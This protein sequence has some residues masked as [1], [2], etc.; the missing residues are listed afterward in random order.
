MAGSEPAPESRTVCGDP[1][2]TLRFPESHAAPW[3]WTPLPHWE[4]L[5]G[6]FQEH[7]APRPRDQGRWAPL[8]G[9]R[10]HPSGK[11]PG[12]CWTTDAVL[13]QASSPAWLGTLL[14]GTTAVSCH[15]K[16]FGGHWPG[17]TLVW[18]GWP[19]GVDAIH[20][21]SPCSSPCFW[22]KT[23]LGSQQPLPSSVPRVRLPRV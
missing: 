20:T 23:F 21:A 10:A 16:G 15:A 22:P 3:P 14:L 11:D 17:G 18:V 4:L 5:V 13:T 6:V 1:I 19:A 8:P 12:Q 7:A 2:L 9:L